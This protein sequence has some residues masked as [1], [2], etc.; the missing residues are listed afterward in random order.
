MNAWF[1]DPR[2]EKAELDAFEADRAER[3]GDLSTALPLHKKAGEGFA[4]VALRV[5]ADHPKTRSA[6]AIAAV[7]SFARAGDF[8]Q[9]VKYGRRFLAE[10]D[11]LSEHGRRELREMISEYS[12]VIPAARTTSQ[13]SSD[14][15]ASKRAQVRDQFRRAA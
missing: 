8:G 5:P 4:V 1:K 15:G 7:A 10:G 3:R 12:K 14:L 6:L 11:A 2:V 9:A 13:Q